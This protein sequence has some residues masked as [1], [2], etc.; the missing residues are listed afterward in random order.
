LLLVWLFTEYLS[1]YQTKFWPFMGF[2]FM[3]LTTLAY[4]FAL[5]QGGG[6]MTGF[7]IG[8]VVV[9]VLVDL[10]LIGTS[11]RARKTREIVVKGERVG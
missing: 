1:V 2:F 8:V 10:G 4:A 7:G 9:A 6:S 11:N 3:P 5:H